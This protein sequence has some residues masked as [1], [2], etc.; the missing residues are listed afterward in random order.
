MTSFARLNSD[1]LDICSSSLLEMV[2]DNETGETRLP[3]HAYD[4]PDRMRSLEVF[5]ERIMKEKA[6][7]EMIPMPLVDQYDRILT[8]DR[9]WCRFYLPCLPSYLQIARD[10][11]RECQYSEEIEVFLSC[12]DAHSVPEDLAN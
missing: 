1:D 12:Y 3:G 6:E 11:P 10:L 5:L 4:Y 8:K 9:S 7:W 2:V